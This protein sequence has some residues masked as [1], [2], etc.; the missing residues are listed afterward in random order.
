MD[1]ARSWRERNSGEV[2][3]VVESYISSSVRQVRRRRALTFAV[4]ILAVVTLAV[5]ALAFQAISEAQRANKARDE[6]DALRIAGDARASL[7]SRP[8]LGLLLAMEAA[9][10]ST[11]P[12]VQSMPLAALTHGPGARRFEDV[13]EPID[14]AALDRGGSHAV[15][16]VNDGIVLWDVDQGAATRTLPV[17]SDVVAISGDG[18]MVALGTT[19]GVEIHP[20]ASADHTVSCD[21]GDS[22]IAELALSD[23]GTK[24]AVATDN[25][26]GSRVA[27]MSFDASTCELDHE[28]AD[29]VGSVRSVAFDPTGDYLALG[30]EGDG[31][32]VWDVETGDP[33]GQVGDGTETVRAVAFG[34]NDSV[35]AATVNGEVLLEYVTDLD[36]DPLQFRID[37]GP[38]IELL[39]FSQAD[40]SLLTG[41]A[42]GELRRIDPTKDPAIGPAL[43]ALPPLDYDGES[44]EPKVLATAGAQ[45]VSIDSTGRVVIWD[46]DGRPP[47][48]P[49]LARGRTVTLVAPSADGS[50]IASSGEEIWRVDPA[51]GDD[52][53][54]A[55]VHGITT[56]ATN[57][58]G[59]AAGTRDG[60]VLTGGASS[61]SVRTIGTF[62]DRKVVALAAL[63]D[64][65]WATALDGGDGGGSI[66]V[67]AADRVLREQTMPVTPA[68]P[69]TPAT[70]ASLAVSDTRAYVG[71]MDGTI[72]VFG[73]DDLQ[74]AVQVKAHGFDIA[75]MAL[76][77]DA[78]L[79]ATGSD[80]R[81]IGLWDVAG[82][83]APT[84]HSRLRG[85]EE[86][87]R[88]LTFSSDGRWLASAGEEPAV[89]LWDLESERAVVDPIRVGTAPVVRF[90][91]NADRRL[92]VADGGLSAWDMRADQWPAIACRI[93]G[94]R[95]LVEVE[96]Q[97]YL[98]DSPVRAACP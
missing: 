17:S 94:S 79:L 5:G 85:H 51:T 52:Q 39:A 70:P 77:P 62:P 22:T 58:T 43:R 89:L 47:L 44:Y 26:D 1:I 75:S 54:L 97:Q 53:L 96:R 55:K 2:T 59:W 46:L 80:D 36:A 14:Q 69:T 13:G 48:G 76:S 66:A 19:A 56:L 38:Q 3:P 34:S 83:G 74:P 78:S 41:T 84:P 9:A 10:R 63:P 98:G 61:D 45:G 57:E 91:P 93:L 18:T 11:T 68:S 23:D 37:G 20:W 15:L 7:D 81:T 82:D 65:G 4:P 67:M 24:V 35:A 30:T 95:R 49:D 27:V 71:D 72:H 29:V 88:S 64:G 12:Q 40:N 92:L 28:L 21:I 42:T 33:E 50:L 8:D 25:G 31:A 6:A 60:Q 87:V 16:R 86:R 32:G 73:L 90:N